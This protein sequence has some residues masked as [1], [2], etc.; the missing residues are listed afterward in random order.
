M[1]PE[2]S[3]RYLQGSIER[4]HL[5]ADVPEEVR[6]NFERARKTYLYG[7]VE[8]DLFT[9][10]SRTF[11]ESGG[12]LRRGQLRAGGGPKSRRAGRLQGGPVRP[13]DAGRPGCAARA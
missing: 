1:A 6:G 3:L 5:A 4:V 10:L 8:F 2:D 7:L 12:V 11:R 9:D 13:R